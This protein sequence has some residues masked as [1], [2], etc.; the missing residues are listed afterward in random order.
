[1]ADNTSIKRDPIAL[2]KTLRKNI[3][4]ARRDGERRSAVGVPEMSALAD[5]L[6]AAA[7]SPAPAQCVPLTDERAREIAAEWYDDDESAIELVRRTE[8]AHGI[9]AAGG[10]GTV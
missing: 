4:G 10:K 1:M 2:A 6:S 3:A 7:T 5:F 8:R 9:G